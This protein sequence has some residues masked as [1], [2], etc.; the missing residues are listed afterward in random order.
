VTHL[1]VGERLGPITRL[2]CSLET[3]RT[4]QIRVHCEFAGHPV[5]GD[6]VYSGLRRSN[7]P[8]LDKA[9]MELHGQALHA[10]ELAFQQPRTGEALCFHASTPPE[11]DELEQTS[12]AVKIDWR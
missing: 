5:V 7:I 10:H 8:S 4:H 1:Q 3:G 6:P 2:E 12:H 11:L 9:V